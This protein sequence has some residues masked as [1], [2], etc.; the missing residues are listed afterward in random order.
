MKRSGKEG[1]STAIQNVMC[2]D[3]DGLNVPPTAQTQLI[4]GLTAGWSEDALQA[5]DVE[6]PSSVSLAK[7]NDVQVGKCSIES[8]NLLM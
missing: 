7:I 3:L 1:G 6:E 5:G 2:T 4:T 8:C